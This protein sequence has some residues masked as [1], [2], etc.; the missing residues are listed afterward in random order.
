MTPPAIAPIGVDLLSDCVESCPSLAVVVEKLEL[1]VVVDTLAV[2]VG[3]SEV[4]EEA[5]E[6]EERDVEVEI[7]DEDEDE[8]PGAGRGRSGPSSS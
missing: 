5:E 3:A 1:V 7:D 8:L 4:N 2:F 6:I